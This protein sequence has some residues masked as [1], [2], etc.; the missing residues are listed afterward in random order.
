MIGDAEFSRAGSA[1]EEE[2]HRL[3]CSLV[4][5]GA[6][7]LELGCGTGGLLAAL[8]PSRGLG[9]DSE[10]RIAAARR[11]HGERTELEFDSLDLQ[12]A[13]LSG[14]EP[15]D[16]VLLSDLAFLP[17]DV[18]DALKRLQHVC[19]PTTRIVLS[20]PSNPWRPLFSLVRRADVGR[21]GVSWL[22]SR[23][24]RNLLELAGF[25]VVTGG[26][27]TL[28][29]LRIPG[30]SWLLNRFL[31]K[32]P[33]VRRLCLTRYLVA[34]RRPERGRESAY[35]VSIVVPTLNERGNVEGVFTR[36][37]AM[38]LWVELVLVDGHSTDGTREEIERNIASHGN[39]F[40]QVQLLDQEGHG[41]GQAVRQGMAACAGDILMILD[42]DLTVPPEELPKFY[43][44][45]AAGHGELINGCRLVYPMERHSMPFLN[46]VA[47][48][49]FAILF[50]WLLDQPVKDT[51][52]GTKVLWRRDCEG[53]AADRVYFGDFDPFGDFDLLFGAARLSRKIVD[54]P[55]HYMARRYGETRI[56]RWSH[57]M[58]LLR[59]SAVAFRRL[60]LS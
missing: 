25:E 12:S 55:I 10:A 60:K 9:V 48:H 56:R 49:L 5:P 39:R 3:F 40:A 4:P 28:L 53:I 2:L 47:N 23:D 33:V 13:D 1:H 32:L 11:I 14:Y 44:A 17:D 46:V 22:S 27:R 26:G 45:I 52:C 57:G 43:E 20:F 6:A 19:T 30:L 59:A 34:R 15:F 54:L 24:V 42:S 31:A 16:Y 37:P 50:T 35:S 51:L 36:I 7:V 8:R 38:G 21:G 58:L 18:A 41:K 29:P